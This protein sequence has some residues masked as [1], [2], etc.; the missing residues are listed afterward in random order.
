MWTQVK[1][2]L[3]FPYSGARRTKSPGQMEV[4]WWSNWLSTQHSPGNLLAEVWGENNSWQK[5]APTCLFVCLVSVTVSL[6]MCDFPGFYCEFPLSDLSIC[7][8]DLI[9]TY[10][11]CRLISRINSINCLVFGVVGNGHLDSGVNHIL[12]KHFED[13]VRKSTDAEKSPMT[14]LS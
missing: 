7:Y 1:L 11:C 10:N 5:K 2:L 12:E 8:F 4:D 3:T 14:V 6:Q 13:V 9:Y